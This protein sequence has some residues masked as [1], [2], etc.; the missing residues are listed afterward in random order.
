LCTVCVHLRLAN[1]R[2]TRHNLQVHFRAITFTLDVAQDGQEGFEMKKILW[3]LL[4]LVVATPVLFAQN[5]PALFFSDLTWGPKT[6]WSGPS[7]T[8]KG[9]AVTVWGNN[10]GTSGTVNAC[11]QSLPSSDSSKVAEWGATT[12]P[13]VPRGL[14]RITFW[15]NSSM[16]ATCSEGI[17]VTT[18]GST[19]A[20][21]PFTIASGNIY[22]VSTTGSDSN[23]GQLATP[24]RHL[25][26]FNPANGLGDN[27]YIVYIRGGTYGA[28]SAELDPNG[29]GG[30]DLVEFCGAMGSSTRQKAL[31]TYPTELATI[32]LRYTSRGFDYTDESG[33]QHLYMTFSKLN[34]D[35][36]G[37]NTTQD[38]FDIYGQYWRF[39]GSNIVN[40]RPTS[41]IQSGFLWVT[42]S[43]YISIFGNYFYNNGFDSMGHN[44]YI[45]TQP[46]PPLSSDLLSTHEVNVG[47]N[48][49]STPYSNDN[50][51]GAIFLSRSSDTPSGAYT[52]HI[53][54]HH[55]YFHD[56]TQGDFIYIGDGSQIDYV[57]IYNNIF[58]GGTSTAGYTGAPFFQT[59]STNIFVYNNTIY[60]VAG[61]SSTNSCIYSSAPTSAEHIT[62]TN[63]I[64]Y[65]NP[66][67]RMYIAE[68]GI[69]SWLSTND[70]FY[71]PSG[72]ATF[73]GSITRTNPLTQ[74]PLFVTNGSN[75]SLQG[76][77]PARSAGVNLYTRLATLPGG[78]VDYAG[79]P[80]PSSGAW[81]VGAMQYGLGGT[82]SG[83]APPSG[84][85]ATVQ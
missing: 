28:S 56:G 64:C 19:T 72:A 31:I 52:H 47:W 16:S 26:K 43:E 32:S 29:C 54:L 67:Y 9:A 77:S 79:L 24:F 25:Y 66:G 7:D 46:G 55:N 27:Q 30:G 73:S 13:T 37:L 20:A 42:G 3:T 5:Q 76:T 45:K 44:I 61:G 33:A 18:G 74:N 4:V 35:M 14:S 15:L 22:F 10:L 71:N 78:N 21:L 6:G 38:V 58:N 50:H 1:S 83:P 85:T 34:F 2:Y 48:E 23:N 57:Y 63:N 82:S 8:V 49:I 60:Q 70:L 80:Y 81:D 17:S 41:Q 39:V 12:N 84:L 11:G 40:D 68:S 51:G 69:G 36:A 65:G 75:F 53:Y 62:T 59:G